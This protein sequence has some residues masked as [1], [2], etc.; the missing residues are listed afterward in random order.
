M[1]KTLELVVA[2]FSCRRPTPALCLVHLNCLSCVHLHR[3]I[4]M[5]IQIYHVMAYIVFNFF[6]FS[7]FHSNFPFIFLGVHCAVLFCSFAWFSHGTALNIHFFGFNGNASER[8]RVTENAPRT[9]KSGV[10]WNI[11]W[12]CQWINNKHTSNVRQGLIRNWLYEPASNQKNER[13]NE[14]KEE[15][16]IT[17]SGGKQKKSTYPYIYVWCVYK[18]VKTKNEAREPAHAILSTEQE[19]RCVKLSSFAPFLIFVALRFFFHFLPFAF[20]FTV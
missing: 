2:V 15:K 12:H 10:G 7:C 8:E 11:K 16:R 17:I 4:M 20:R 19:I 18:Y 1:K 6:S 5:R 9:R 13:K 14:N 3:K